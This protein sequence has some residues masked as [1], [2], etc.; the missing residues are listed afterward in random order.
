MKKAPKVA[1][2][3]VTL[4]AVLA[5][6]F[7]VKGRGTESTDD[8]QVEGHIVNIAARVPGQVQ[9][10]FVKDNQSVKKGDIL[11]ELD[12]TELD[13]RVAG[14]KA[15][16]SAAESSLAA[17]QSDVA[18]HHSK[19]RLADV[20]LERARKL[21]AEGVLA[22][23]ELDAKSAEYDQS[24]ANYEQAVA[25]LGNVQK[26]GSVGAALARVQQAEA[27]LQL[28]NVNLS[29]AKIVAPIDGIVS[30]RSVEEGQIVTPSTPLL[31]LVGT[32]D[33]WVVANFKED[34]LG[35]MKIGQAA[36][37]KID[38]IRGKTFDAELSSF[39][40]ATG[41]KF[42]LIPPDNASGNFVKV[43][44]RIPVLLHFKALTPN[45]DSAL[46]LRPGMSAEV[47]VRTN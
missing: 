19:L 10:V 18:L 35:D 21:F 47:T 25:R 15:D 44:Q 20:E 29:Y 24:K 26:E 6:I 27:G 9:K 30:R 31:A 4:A 11:V 13:A 32:G 41:S 38:G 5:L 3:L 23:A 36:N 22:K 43:V 16:L 2:G 33:V 1:L 34:Q 12:S 40:A 46:A 14:A 42:A 7:W 17:G 37:V 28:A 39:G 8:A 45:D